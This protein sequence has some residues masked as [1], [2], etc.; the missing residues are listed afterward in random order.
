ML[1][2]SESHKY[3]LYICSLDE[4]IRQVTI[5]CAERGLL[6]LRMRDEARMTMDAYQSLYC[7]S[8]AFGM[9]KALQAEQG[10][11]DLEAEIVSL[12]EAKKDLEKQVMELRMKSEQVERRANEMREAEDK[13]HTEEI[14]FLKKTNQQLKVS[15]VLKLD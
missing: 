3:Y 12:K 8:I 5:N 14:T 13:K 4:I 11:A 10:K 9:R 6:L 2:I 15:F 7:S 1:F